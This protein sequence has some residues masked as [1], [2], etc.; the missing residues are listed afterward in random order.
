MIGLLSFII[1]LYLPGIQG[2]K[3]C[4][5]GFSFSKSWNGRFLSLHGIPFYALFFRKKKI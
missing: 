3:I 1:A 4:A 2:N 5:I